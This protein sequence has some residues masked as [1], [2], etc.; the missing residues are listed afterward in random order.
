MALE[1]PRDSFIFYRSFFDGASYL[2]D[3]QRLALYEAIAAK[4]LYGIDP[5][6]KLDG[7]VMGMYSMALPQ[8]EANQKRYE[9]GK[10]GADY[11]KR[12]GRPPGTQ[13]NENPTGGSD[14]KSSKTPLGFPSETP[15]VNENENVNENVNI[16][17]LP[18]LQGDRT[19][20]EETSNSGESLEFQTAT[21]P[22]APPRPAKKPAASLRQLSAEQRAGFETFWTAWPK[23]VS[24]GQAENTWGKLRPDRELLDKILAGLERA[25]KMDRR[26][27]TVEFTPHAS[28]WLNDRGWE[29]EYA[30]DQKAV[31]GASPSYDLEEFKRQTA[32]SVPKI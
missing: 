16:T 6:P 26:F 21:G 8:L 15:N 32:F 30:S 23:K 11:G 13:K 24:K 22:K 17:P 1:N 14:S 4:A 20:S 25:K 7:V 28:T 2:P 19:E 9:D 12:G 3:D 10:K 27:Q 29:D 31:A 5:D 18:P